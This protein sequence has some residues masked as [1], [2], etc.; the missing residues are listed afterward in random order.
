MKSWILHNLGLKILSVM[1]AV[2]IWWLIRSE[3]HPH[4]ENA[5][6]LPVPTLHLT[7]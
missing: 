5:A 3:V 2:L 7:P 4:H 6:D 1:L